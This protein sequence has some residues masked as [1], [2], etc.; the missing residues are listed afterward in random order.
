MVPGAH[1][2]FFFTTV[3]LHGADAYTWS[4]QGTPTQCSNLTVDI[5]G[6]DGTPPFRILISPFGPSPLANN[7]EA[8]NILDIPFQDNQT[9][10]QFQLTYPAGSQFVAVVSAFLRFALRR[11]RIVFSSYSILEHRHF[12]TCISLTTWKCRS[13]MRQALHPVGQVLPPLWQPRT[14]P[15]ATARSRSSSSLTSNPQTSLYS[16]NPCGYGGTHQRCKGES[17]IPHLSLCPCVPHA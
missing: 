13:V 4:Y 11:A 15:R 3:V 2:F 12:L 9:K 14:T 5:S 7:V 17:G 16:A 1:F 10:V 6:S 8:R